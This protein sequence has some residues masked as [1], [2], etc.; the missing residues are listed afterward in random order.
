MLFR[1]SSPLPLP[2]SPLTPRL[3]VVAVDD[4]RSIFLNGHLVARYRGED[5]TEPV[6]VTQLAEVVPWPD[7]QI[8]AAFDVHPVT[9]S[10]FRR[11]ARQ[12]GAVALLPRKT[13]PQGPSKTTPPREA[14]CRVCAL[15]DCPC[16]PSPS[17]SRAA[18]PLSPTS[19]WRL[20]STISRRRLNNRPCR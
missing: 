7:R 2:L 10:R 18:A 4:Q 19:A 14:R 12:G 6:L 17:A 9:L 8:A 15:R 16:R 11:P 3:E 13:G 1:M 20:C 5:K